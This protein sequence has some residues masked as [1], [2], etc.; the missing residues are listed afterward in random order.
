[1]HTVILEQRKETIYAWE[2]QERQGELPI[3]LDYNELRRRNSRGPLQQQG[4]S[5][6]EQHVQKQ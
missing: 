1:M 6:R 5:L 4:I 2:N 3:V